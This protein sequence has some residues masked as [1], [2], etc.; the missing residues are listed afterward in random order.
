MMAPLVLGGQMGVNGSGR[1]RLGDE[2]F[3]VK[4]QR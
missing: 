1:V 3:R 4:Q 2:E